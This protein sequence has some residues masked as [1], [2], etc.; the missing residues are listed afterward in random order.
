MEVKV[1]RIHFGE[2]FTVGKMYVDGQDVKIFVLEDKVREV[3]GQPVSSWKIDEKTAIPKGRYRMII[4]M[5][6][7]FKK[8]MPLLL[9]VEGFTGVRIHAGNV[10]TSTEGCLLLG[11]SWDGKSDWI[12]ESRVAVNEFMAII[13]DQNVTVEIG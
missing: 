12:G 6:N 1:K 13:K 5:S 4:N 9:D 10:S 3:E 2:N 7:R 8:L 11:K